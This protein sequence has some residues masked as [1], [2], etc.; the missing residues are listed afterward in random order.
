MAS[1]GDCLCFSQEC[2]FK[3]GAEQFK[4]GLETGKDGFHAKLLLPCCTF[5]VKTPTTCV[6]A[7]GNFLCVHV[8]A[9]LPP[10]AEKPL[11]CACC[12]VVCANADGF[13]VGVFKSLDELKGQ[14][15]ASAPKVPEA[16]NRA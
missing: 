7:S 11:T 15:V 6:E 14:A 12:F 16:M 5:G 10:T 3:T 13:K 4:P 1:K 8:D 9:A 2:C